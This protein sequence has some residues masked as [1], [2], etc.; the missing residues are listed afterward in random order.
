MKPSSIAGVAACMLITAFTG[1]QYDTSTRH[2][3]R[4]PPAEAEI[5]G[6]YAPDAASRKR[7]VELPMSNA[8]LPLDASGSITLSNNHAAE[9][10][11][12]PFSGD[13]RKACS[14]TGNGT[15]NI[16]QSQ[17]YE[18]VYIQIRNMERDS[19]CERDFAYPLMLYG[20]NP[21]Y[22]LHLIIDDPDLGQFV[23]FEKQQ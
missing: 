10:V 17:G 4:T 13:G 1:C 8:V 5:V 3:L 14:I 22:K 2:Y 19:P 11:R 23:Q 16:G 15:W 6:K 12:V 18:H 20:H 7:R 9:F 21:P